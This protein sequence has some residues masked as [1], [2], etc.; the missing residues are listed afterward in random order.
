MPG[1]PDPNQPNLMAYLHH[2][3]GQEKEVRIFDADHTY[4][5]AWN[6]H[7]DANIKA[8][9]AKFLFMKHFPKH[10]LRGP[11]GNDAIDVVE[12]NP[13]PFQDGLD[14]FIAEVQALTPRT[15]T[16]PSFGPG[17][18]E[19]AHMLVEKPLA[20]KR[21]WSQTKHKLWAKS[22]RILQGDRLARLVCEGKV[23]EVIVKRNLIE[24]AA[25]RFRQ[26]FAAIAAWDASLL[27]WLHSTLHSH[28][29]SIYLVTYHEAM[30]ILRQK[31]PS[32]VDKFYLPLKYDSG[33]IARSK[34]MQ[35]DP[36]LTALNN[37]RPV[38]INLEMFD[39]SP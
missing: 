4:A 34:Q 12:V 36:V 29:I 2:L 6:R 7:P 17:L 22:L 5:R 1:T 15:P 19:E 13:S 9:S 20:D 37:H 21:N 33:A 26:A 3:S 39:T 11:L 24:K 18:N 25:S 14:P 30:Q 8:R 23:D 27:S 28:V 32:L 38:S 31:V 10:F 35:S 16:T